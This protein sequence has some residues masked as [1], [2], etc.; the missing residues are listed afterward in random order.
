M[1]FCQSK[2]WRIHQSHIDLSRIVINQR[3]RTETIVYNYYQYLRYENYHHHQVKWYLDMVYFAKGVIIFVS[4]IIRINSVTSQ[5]LLLLLFCFLNI[6][7]HIA[8]VPACSSGTS[9]LINVLLRRNAM[10]QKQDM[11]PHPSQYTDIGPTFRCAI[12]WCGTSHCNTQQPILMSSVR[13]GREILPWPST[14]SSECSTLWCS[15]VGNQS[16]A[17]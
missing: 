12:H 14:H 4:Q 15:Y 2:V 5:L 11:T 16:E 17:R 1:I 10:P 6:C 7:G 8:T 13:P 9:T 3:P